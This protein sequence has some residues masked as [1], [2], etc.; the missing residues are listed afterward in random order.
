[1]LYLLSHSFG[2]AKFAARSIQISLQTDL[3]EG[4]DMRQDVGGRGD[5][6][7][8]TAAGYRPKSQEGYKSTILQVRERIGDRCV[9]PVSAEVVYGS[10]ARCLR[11]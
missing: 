8:E 3:S 4:R 5:N 10:L 7:K 6:T 2:N 1:M 11:R 9:G